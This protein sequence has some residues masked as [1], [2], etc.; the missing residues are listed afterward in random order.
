VLGTHW[1]GD[2]YPGGTVGWRNGG[3]TAVPPTTMTRLVQ[4]DLGAPELLTEVRGHFLGGK[5]GGVYFP[6]NI[7]AR[8]S[9][10]G[11]TWGDWQTLWWPNPS[12]DVIGANLSPPP[13]RWYPINFQTPEIGRHIQFEF[14]T[15]REWMMI[16][17][18]EANLRPHVSY[19]ADQ[20][21]DRNW[22]DRDGNTLLDGISPAAAGSGGILWY[23]A[24][25][26]GNGQ[27]TSIYIDLGQEQDLWMVGAELWNNLS[28]GAAMPDEFL[29]RI[30]SAASGDYATTVWGDWF[31]GT[32]DANG[33]S[34]G[35]WHMG[36]GIALFG[37]GVHGRYLQLAFGEDTAY[38][39]ADGLFI[40]EIRLV[41]EPAT[42]A[43]LACGLSALVLRRRRRRS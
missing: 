35:A 33:P 1:A 30:G 31:A 34:D 21:L 20:R 10:D 2:P 19:G 38:T 22:A 11:A 17:E 3:H 8:T 25:D 16:T 24:E 13:S 4:I 12:G 23:R 6:E 42:M 9:L 26:A 29:V 41:P 40:S 14:S 43:M 27:D 28:L 5:V 37:E 36:R 39:G 18:V 32:V 15:T 7:R